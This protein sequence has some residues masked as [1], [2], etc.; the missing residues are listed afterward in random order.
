MAFITAATF[1]EEMD[2]AQDMAINF[3]NY[4]C[5]TAQYEKHGEWWMA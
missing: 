4:L 5:G 3:A 1:A 2:T